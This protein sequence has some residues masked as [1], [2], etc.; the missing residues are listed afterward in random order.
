MKRGARIFL[1]NS[2]NAVVGPFAW[3]VIRE[4]VAFGLLSVS[5]L[6]YLEGGDSWQPLDQIDDLVEL[7]KWLVDS[8]KNR[9]VCPC[10]ERQRSYLRHLGCPFDPDM[11]DRRVAS[12]LIEQLSAVYPERV[13]SE[14][15]ES[16]SSDADWHNDP[17]TQRQVEYLKLIGLKIDP[18]I[19]KGRAYQLISGEVTEG[20]I[21]R[22]RFYQIPIEH[23]LTK[24]EASELIEQLYIRASRIRGALSRVDG[25]HDRHLATRV[26]FRFDIS[27][28]LRA[29]SDEP[30]RGVA[31]FTSD[32][33]LIPNKMP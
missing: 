7:P 23:Y 13:I 19:T 14:T 3:S 20:Q 27:R 30:C 21:R 1:T 25:I 5:S 8:T 18:G 12:R 33:Q 11:I 16:L 15:A 6:G 17:A 9:S 28:S 29:I 4:W 24:E 10:T 26:I 22:L 31:K 2:A 32:R